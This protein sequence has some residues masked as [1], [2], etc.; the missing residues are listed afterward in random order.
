[1]SFRNDVKP[2]LMNNCVQCHGGHAGLYVDSYDSRLVPSSKSKV[3]LIEDPGK[4]IIVWNLTGMIQ[5]RMPLNGPSLSEQ[6]IATIET[7]IREGAPNDQGGF[8]R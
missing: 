7:W 8:R 5:P 6:E 4:S 1:M 2:I 3:V